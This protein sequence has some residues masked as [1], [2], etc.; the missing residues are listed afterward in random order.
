MERSW[1]VGKKVWMDGEG[2]GTAGRHNGDA[3]W[4]HLAPP[5]MLTGLP[6]GCHFTME[7]RRPLGIGWFVQ[8]LG[9]GATFLQPLP[10]RQYN[11]MTVTSA[12]HRP[13]RGRP[14][15]SASYP[16]AASWGLVCT[17]EESLER[18]DQA[19]G[20]GTAG[21]LHLSSLCLPGAHTISLSTCDLILGTIRASQGLP[22]QGP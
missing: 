22:E 9:L 19:A 11:V 5:E 1:G 14:S 4:V 16:C 20:A 15:A 21:S 7:T 2:V 12:V 13:W 6:R 10:T 8:G 18:G 17:G 3:Q